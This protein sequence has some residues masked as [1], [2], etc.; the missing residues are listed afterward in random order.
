LEGQDAEG[1][2]W[3]EGVEVVLDEVDH[4]GFG[5]IVKSQGIFG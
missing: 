3:R 5:F 1:G 2:L 4:R